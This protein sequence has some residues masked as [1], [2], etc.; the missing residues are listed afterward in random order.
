MT[1]SRLLPLFGG[2]FVLFKGFFQFVHRQG[3]LIKRPLP[4]KPTP[5]PVIF[6]CGFKSYRLDFMECIQPP[7]FPLRQYLWNDR[8]N[9]FAKLFHFCILMVFLWSLV[10]MKRRKERIWTINPP[11]GHLTAARCD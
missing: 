2:S 10:R 7:L 3:L 6:H 4:M 1:T 11:Y 5:Q 9:L 8:R